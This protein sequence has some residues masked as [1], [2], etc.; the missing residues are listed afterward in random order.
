MYCQEQSNTFQNPE[1]SGQASFNLDRKVFVGNISYRIGQMRLKQ[2]FKKFGTV[3]YCYIVK[4]HLKKSSKGIAF[5]TFKDQESVQRA[6]QATDDDLTLDN[7]VMRV[8]PAEISTR[9]T[10]WRD[11][12]KVEEEEEEEEEKKDD[13]NNCARS[14]HP[15][16]QLSG[17]QE[18]TSSTCEAKDVTKAVH[19]SVFILCEEVLIHIFSFLSV[20][21]R[22]KIERVCQHWRDIALK[23][24]G[25]Q[26]TLH[27]KN[28]FLKQ[29]GGLTDKILNLLLSRCGQHLR[30]LDLSSSPR[31]LT[32]FVID[33]IAKYCV[34]LESLDVSGVKVTDISMRNL[35]N[36]GKSLKCVKLHHCIHFGEKGLRTLLSTCELLEYL[37]IQEN[38]TITGASFQSASPSLK[39]LLLNNC[40]QLTDRGIQNLS[41]RCS[42]LENIQLN[43]CYYISDIGVTTLCQC[44]Q[45]LKVLHMSGNFPNV[46]DETLK[47]IH[48]LRKLREL[49]VSFNLAVN[50]SVLKAISDSCEDLEILDISGCHHGVTGFG[51]SYLSQSSCL[52]TVNL[53]YL[54]KVSGSSVKLLAQSGNLRSLKLQADTGITDEVLETVAV[55]NPQLELLDVSGNIQITVKTLKAFIQVATNYPESRIQLILGGCSVLLEDLANLP[56]GVSVSLLDLS[57]SHLRPDREIILPAEDELVSSDDENDK[58]GYPSAEGFACDLDAGFDEIVWDDYDDDNGDDYLDND[59]PL[60]AERWKLS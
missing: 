1:E 26:K 36:L 2:F 11:D 42:G 9:A 48:I 41:Q 54:P 5:V 53:S 52:H 56:A 43:K 34:N 12:A 51:V 33:I 40:T 39:S 44:F 30:Q 7:R 8:K 16:D 47:K 49:N 60:E 18:G 21:E 59:D 6:L 19:P 10:F 55:L 13:L 45:N 31:M 50:D 37:D 14:I 28:F 32:D 22:I 20:Q 35:G 25:H 29:F 4:D 57:R 24:W 46:T 23:S 38:S 27:F 3:D 15:P 17:Y 58:M